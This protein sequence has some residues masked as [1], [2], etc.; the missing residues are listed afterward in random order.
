MDDPKLEKICM[1][2]NS[3]VAQKS[4]GNEKR[5]FC[6]PPAVILTGE[7]WKVDGE[8]PIIR[9]GIE[10]DGKDAQAGSLD[11]QGIAVFK[12]LYISDSDK[13]KNFTLYLRISSPDGRDYGVFRSK[14]IKVISK[15]SKKKQSVKNVDLCITSGT[16]VALFNRIRSQT[17]STKYL[18][19]ENG[20][21]VTKSSVWDAFTVTA[22]GKVPDP[23]EEMNLH[24]GMDIILQSTLTGLQSSVLVIRK[25]E[26]TEAIYDCDEPISQL[27]KVALFVK[28]SDR[29]YLATVNDN[30]T[31]EK[32]VP[33]SA[34]SLD[35]TL[36]DA[37]AWTIVGTDRIKYGFFD[38]A[39]PQKVIT[40]VPVVEYVK[41]QNK[42]L[43]ELYGENFSPNLTVYFA[44]TPSKTKYRCEE[45]LICEPPSYSQLSCSGGNTHC[46]TRTE[47]ALY[48]VRQDGAVY[49]TGQKYTYQAEPVPFPR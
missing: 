22:V 1:I 43:V 25:V 41:I 17:V 48:L 26:K 2:L 16:T 15:P 32:G 37:A 21:F 5:F 19:V 3:K 34:N 44:D 46:K 8:D 18:G 24:Y 6:P 12:N 7:A 11:P 36:S 28:D 49:S 10:E 30:V 23:G 9:L 39:V 35:D 20:G 33:S 13:R 45:F 40:P 14:P 4:Y 29:S 38:H 31:M 27:H 42:T 47:V